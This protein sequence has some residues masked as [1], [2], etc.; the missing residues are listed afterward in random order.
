MSIETG[1]Y[2]FPAFLPDIHH[3]AYPNRPRIRGVV[4]R[5][6]SVRENFQPERRC[7]VKLHPHLMPPAS[8]EDL[9][10]RN[11]FRHGLGIHH[12]DQCFRLLARHNPVLDTEPVLPVQYRS[13]CSLPELG[14]YGSQVH[15]RPLP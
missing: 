2:S 7:G 5:D 1:R 13:P 6:R 4:F 9:V 8:K 11:D 12:P 15:H 10:V 14:Q 3:K